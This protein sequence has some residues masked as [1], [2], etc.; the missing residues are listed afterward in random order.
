MG[1]PAERDNAVVELRRSERRFRD[2][3]EATS[4]WIWE[5]DR[6]HRFT[7]VSDKIHK[8][9]GTPGSAFIGR[10]VAEV[11]K[12]AEGPEVARHI[13]DLD[14]HKPIVNFTY[15]IERPFGRRCCT[16]TGHPIFD[17]DG[18]FC[19]Y[20]GIGSDITELKLAQERQE[21]LVAE[22]R[23]R[24]KNTLTTVMSL[25]T[26]TMRS[27]TDLQH[28][29]ESFRARLG[30]MDRAH[31]LLSS[32]G[33]AGVSLR[34]LLA[35]ELDAYRQGE[36]G[37]IELSGPPITVG[38]NAAPSLA[39]V[40]HEL[41]TNALKY[42]ALSAPSGRLD[43]AW[44]SD[45][46]R[47]VIDWVERDGPPVAPPTR[48]GFGSSLLDKALK[49]DLDGSTTLRFDPAGLRCTLDLDYWALTSKRR[50]PDAPAS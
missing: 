42:G 35:G 31:D 18:A 39:L 1:K 34:D 41:T 44:R 10:T 40:L 30:A 22:L 29:A 14:L 27:A 8:V 20:R 46:R 24:L 11:M 2:I 32:D 38:A 50:P 26:L 17:D 3:A 47:L 21:L 43:V 48:S 5:T 23:H 19:G 49:H 16:I 6:D 37:N 28:F 36:G 9:S 33:W 4:D 7:Y 25:M 15:W 13:A 12:G 45:G